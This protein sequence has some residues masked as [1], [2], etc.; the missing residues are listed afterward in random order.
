MTGVRRRGRVLALQALY[1]VD[2]VGRRPQEAL[3]SL[4]REGEDQE[5]AAFARELVSGVADHLEEVDSF[6]QRFAPAYPVAQLSPIDRNILRLAIYELLFTPLIPIK[7]AINEAVELAKAYGSE[8][9]PRFING[10][11]GSVSTPA[12]EKRSAAA[13]SKYKTKEVVK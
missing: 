2:L 3:A 8:S 5:A 9:S 7:V 12:E 4:L 1:Q 10:V 13:P 11:L 6:I